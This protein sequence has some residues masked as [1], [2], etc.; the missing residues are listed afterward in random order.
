[1]ANY[2]N[3]TSLGD[4]VNNKINN[5]FHSHSSVTIIGI[6]LMG[7]ALA[8]TIANAGF[9]ITLWNRDP[10]KAQALQGENIQHAESIL[11]AVKSS[12]IVIVCVRD[13]SVSDELL[14][15]VSIEKALAGK[16]ILQLSTGTPEQAREAQLWAQGIQ[17]SYLDGAILA[18]P[19]AIGTQQCLILYAGNKEVFDRCVAVINAFAGTAKHVGCDSGSAAALD[20]A[21]LS[22]YFG[23]VF[24]ALNGAAICDAQGI[25]LSLFGEMGTLML[26][27]FEGVLSRSVDMIERDNFESKYSNLMTSLGALRQ[28]SQLAESSQ[29]NSELLKTMQQMAEKGVSEGHGALN[30]AVLFK[31]LQR[32]G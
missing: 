24:G 28:I 12:D 29:L 6:G 26:P 21:V 5:D 27:A 2:K 14:R 13:Y 4:A 11:A 18:F 30:N 9:S 1:M 25:D 23:F 22:I 15:T 10:A 31:L 8:R 19:D 7:A 32:K 16:V 3:L 17:A 20:S